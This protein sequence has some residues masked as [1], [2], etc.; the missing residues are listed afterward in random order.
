M[1][2]EE[3]KDRKSL[4]TWLKGRSH[5][6]HIWIAYRAALRVAPIWFQGTTQYIET[7]QTGKRF[8]NFRSLILVECLAKRH[9]L[10][11]RNT[12]KLSFYASQELSRHSEEYFQ[13]LS[14]QENLLL[15]ALEAVK[16]G[17]D[18]TTFLAYS[19]AL[20]AVT[21]A[22]K[23]AT[24]S[25]S[26][27][28]LAST[29]DA[30][31]SFVECM[32][33]LAWV[34]E[35]KARMATFD[36]DVPETLRSELSL[37]EDTASAQA[38]LEIRN[39]CVDLSRLPKAKVERLWM[40]VPPTILEFW[41]RVQARWELPNSPYSFW[42]RWYQSALSG[43]EHDFTL[44]HNMAIVQDEDWQKGA[45]H[46][47]SLIANIEKNLE[48]KRKGSDASDQSTGDRAELLASDNASLIHMQIDVL[49][50]LIDSEI[51]RA[52]SANALQEEEYQSRAVRID[53]LA[54]ISAAIQEM[55]NVLESGDESPSRSLVLIGET[56]PVLVEA[57]EDL[58]IE[59]GDPAVSSMIVTMGASIEYL[60][61]RG[62]PGHIA[63]GVAAFDLLRN[64]IRDSWTRLI[65]L[66]TK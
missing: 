46:V 32:G 60:T 34:S 20:K 36:R 29:T 23:A 8:L 7:Q 26:N 3:I 6:E 13:D 50:A 21:Q 2:P 14:E 44:L 1:N 54:D 15:T 48:T 43:A 24:E 58:V 63:A 4:K 35:S 37:A 53:L 66:R 18:E 64:S 19:L 41:N 27:N 31:G 28:S 9:N 38:W 17:Q 47:G 10:L 45:E 49:S 11:F 61:K 59:G 42:L 62:T 16:V 56:L 52:R 51:F 12:M 5:E 33:A 30:V 57:A 40:K 39:D 65:R 25:G 55:R 22:A